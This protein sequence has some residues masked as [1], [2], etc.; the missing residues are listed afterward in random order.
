MEDEPFACMLRDI[1]LQKYYGDLTEIHTNTLDR[2]SDCESNGGEEIIHGYESSNSSETSSPTNEGTTSQSEYAPSPPKIS[3]PNVLKCIDD[4]TMDNIYEDYFNRGYNSY[5]KL[6]NR[7]SCIRSK[8]NCKVI[9][10]YVTCKRQDPGHF[11]GNKTS[12]LKAV[13]ESVRAQFDRARDYGSV[14]HYWH[15]QAW[16][17]DA[18]RAVAL[19]N[20]KASMHFVSS[21]K[22]EYNISSR[23]ITTFMARKEIE[24]HIIRQRAETFVA[25]V[26]MFIKDNNI[27]KE[28]VW[29]SDQSQFFY[30]LSSASTLSHRGEKS[31]AG[32]VQSVHSS[33][34][35]YTID[36]AVSMDGRLAN[37]LYICLQEPQGTF[38]PQVA[39]KLATMCPQNIHVEASKSGKMT[40]EHMK[41][42]LHSVL[43]EHVG[44]KGLLLCD[45]WSGHKDYS[46]IEDCFPNKDITLKILPPKTTK[47]C[48][49]LDVY[50]FRQYKLYARR[51]VDFVCLQIDKPQVTVHDRYFIIRLHSVIYN[52]LSA[53]R[54]RPMLTYA[55]QRSSYEV[56]IPVASFDNVITVAF[57][58]GL[59]Q[60]GYTE[61]DVACPHIA[62]VKCAY[63]SI[64]LCFDHFI[65][66]PHLHFDDE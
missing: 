24:D 62:L 41:S 50:C 46:L 8:S 30:E 52:Q 35:S 36:V 19:D 49:P 39:K 1:I 22:E 5:R 59:L 55:W 33:T 20:F 47:Y 64:P 16:A 37:K 3:R 27:L 26:N 4:R 7:Y 58:I 66:M 31:T 25:D 14:V 11:K 43:G 61:D 9:L 63:C 56:D 23:H 48:Q 60:C 6:M 38:G 28:R 29:N 57:D 40:K 53:P 12:K 32:V 18:A 42:F 2:N 10:D 13:K 34:H 44:E 15:I 45:S 54:Y 21:F 65:E 51:L 17:L